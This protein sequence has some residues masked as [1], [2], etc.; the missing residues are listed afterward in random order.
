VEMSV[1]F[2]ANGKVLETETEI[3]KDALPAPVQEALSK[4]FAGYDIDEAAKIVRNG[5][6]TFEAQVEKDENKLDAIYSAAG[7]LIKKVEKQEEG[8]E[9]EKA[10]SGENEEKGKSEQHEKSETASDWQKTFAVD[11][12]SLKNTGTNPYFILRPGYRLTLSGKEDGKKVDLVITVLNETQ[13]IDGVETRIV[14]ERESHN[15]SLVEVSRNFYAIDP[16]SNNVYYFG[17]AV[18]IYKDGK[19]VGHGG[20]WQSGTNGAHFG[21]MMLGQP[22]VEQKYYQEV[23]PGIAMDRAEVESLSKTLATP[24]GRFS[25][26]LKTEETTP[27]EAGVKEYKMYVPGVGLILDGSL[28]LSK[29]GI[30]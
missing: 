5:K 4:D 6:T 14:E 24:A 28:K 19:V 2:D 1:I 17:E 9:S 26:C 30:R 22:Q 29:Y 23:A 10:E 25:N 11:K 12:S 13:M 7:T 15:G 3:E 8:E 16:A 27:L 18:D 21:L 20:A